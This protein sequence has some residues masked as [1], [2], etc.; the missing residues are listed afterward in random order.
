M[1]GTGFSLSSAGIQPASVDKHGRHFKSPA[2]YR[3]LRIASARAANTISLNA[4]ASNNER[5][6]VLLN[7]SGK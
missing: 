6:P 3:G 1:V 7:R 2:R 4:R 5:A